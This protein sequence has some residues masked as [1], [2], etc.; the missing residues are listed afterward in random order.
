[1]GAVG[2]LCASDPLCEV[3]DVVGDFRVG[4]DPGL[5]G[6]LGRLGLTQGERRCVEVGPVATGDAETPLAL[7]DRVFKSAKEHDMRHLHATLALIAGV[8]PRVVAD[9]LGH[10]TTAVTTDIYQHVLPDLDR[11]AATRV[12]A[13]VF[14]ESNP[15]SADGLA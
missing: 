5:A 3:D 8:A 1:L 14:G 4:V 15:A 13:L 10:S 9:R 2:A 7:S 6:V 12:A 11:D